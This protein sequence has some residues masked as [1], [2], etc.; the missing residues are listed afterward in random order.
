MKYCPSC[1]TTYTDDTL[2]FCLQDGTPLAEVSDSSSQQPTVSFTDDETLISPRQVE[3]LRIPV[4]KLQTPDWEQSRE[5]KVSAIPAEPKKSRVALAV[6]LTALVMLLLFGGAI[7]AWFYLKNGKKETAQTANNKAALN[8]SPNPKNDNKT[9]VF[10]SPSDSPKDLTPSPT[11]S[12]T[13]TP[14]PDFNPEKVKKEVSDKIYSWK[15]AAESLNLNAYMNYYANTIDYYN[16]SGA[17]ASY[18][19]NDKQ[20]AFSKYDNIEINLSNMR[21]T[22]NASGD[23]ATA[24][25]DK[26]WTFEGEESYSS[27][28]VQSQIQLKKI[29]D[30]WLITG[31][32][33]LKVYYVDK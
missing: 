2:R 6:F 12:P 30:Q 11:P 26:E 19:R 4:E 8:Q 18:V 1:Q 33:D 15:S 10:P 31:E 25:F 24:V 3:P 13:G 27:G 21:V 20:K 28:K 16:K 22:P 14:M 23:A 5:T 17:S 7:G 9:E 32:K 29:N